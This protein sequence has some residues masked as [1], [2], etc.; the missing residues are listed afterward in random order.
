[1]RLRIGENEASAKRSRFVGLFQR[2]CALLRLPR[3]LHA[4][5][6]AV[7]P[8]PS[9][10]ARP[11]RRAPTVLARRVP[12]VL[13]RRVPTVLARRV[14]TVLARRVLT[15]SRF[16]SARGQ[17]GRCSDGPGARR[18]LASLPHGPNASMQPIQAASRASLDGTGDGASH[19]PQR[20]THN[21][22][23]R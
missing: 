7:A 23:R 14:P 9:L 12:T 21:P 11:P 8:P 2:A 17:G 10:A 4:G 19:G 13:A 5:R 1:M 3:H 15:S 22:Q 16:G 6:A 20:M 18:I